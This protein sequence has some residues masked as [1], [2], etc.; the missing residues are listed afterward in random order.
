MRV[1]G[2]GRE[3]TTGKGMGECVGVKRGSNGIDDD[4]GMEGGSASGAR[5]VQRWTDSG[6]E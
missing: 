2:M 6:C 4:A 5:E 1:G 3:A